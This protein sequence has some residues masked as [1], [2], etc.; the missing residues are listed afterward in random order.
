M[1]DLERL[2]YLDHAHTSAGRIPTDE[3][4]RVYVDSL[5]RRPQLPARDAATIDA[6]VRDS[7]S[8]DRVLEGASRLLSRLSRHV[9]F[10]LAPDLSRTSFLRID[11]VRLA[12]LRIL[13]VMV[14]LA[15]IVTNKV[16]DVEEDMTQDALQQ[17]AN[18]LNAHFQGMQ[19][20]EIRKRL[21]DLMRQEKALYDSLLKAVVSVGRE[22]FSAEEGEGNL[23][24]DGTGNILEGVSFEDLDRMRSLFRTFEE[25]SRL[26]KIL[27]GCIAGT[28]VRV[29]IGH[30]NPH[31]DLSQ[32]A[33]VATPCPIG[34]ETGWGVGVM[35][36]TRMEYARIMALVDYVAQ[37][38]QHA[39][40][41]HHP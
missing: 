38:V 30:E 17:C 26:V 25:K 39:F 22:A 12:P 19:L 4:Y 10:V 1:A 11:L 29:V 32:M 14:S 2:G 20:V 23:Y 41:E 27:N 3:G 40:V 5:E 35:G 13:V 36:S 28:G 33:L 34:G 31:P 8:P 6:V 7:E 21:L 18:Y 9:G 15:G 24:L 37:A 16:V